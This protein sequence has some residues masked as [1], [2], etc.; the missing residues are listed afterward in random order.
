[1]RCRIA[2]LAINKYAEYFYDIFYNYIEGIKYEK[3]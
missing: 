1:M 3:R 2:K